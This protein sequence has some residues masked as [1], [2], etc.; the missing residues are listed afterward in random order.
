LLYGTWTLF[1]H[2]KTTLKRA[3]LIPFIC[4]ELAVGMGNKQPKQAAE[5]PRLF[6][7]GRI[8]DITIFLEKTMK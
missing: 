1:V 5:V 3:N 7:Q 6:C 4:Q 2:D 8:N